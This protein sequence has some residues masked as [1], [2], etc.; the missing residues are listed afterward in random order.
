MPHVRLTGGRLDG[1]DL[2]YTVAGGG[3]AVVLVHGLGG[4]AESWR[5]NVEPLGRRFRVYA[6]DLPGFGGSAKPPGVYDLP[7]FA[8]ALGGFLD[9]LGLGQVTL[10]GHSLG[11]GV[12][13]TYALIHPGRVERLA[14]LAALV[15]GGTFRTA[16]IYRLL[17]RRGLGELLALCG[18][19]P[20]YRAAL[21]RCFHR[22][23]DL[24]PR[25]LR[26]EI[27]FLVTW[28]ARARTSWPARAAYLAT[29]RGLHGDLEH[30]AADY[31]RA[32][33]TLDLPVL[34]IHGRQD[35]VVPSGHCREVAAAIGRA[36]V[37]WVEGCGHFP[38]IEHADA[39]NE[40]LVEFLA[41]RRATR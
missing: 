29:V 28:N 30:R 39:V 27:D 7:F 4:F 26:A 3:P 25:A 13:V 9:A 22:S 20:I 10:V 38:Q 24:D 11:G 6:L 1:L 41:G 32:L 40:W 35:P 37:R 36:D 34:L 31:R 23:P 16:P 21:A 17:T 19:A 2:H 12:A 33:A 14:L 8:S 5:R 15:P 18:C